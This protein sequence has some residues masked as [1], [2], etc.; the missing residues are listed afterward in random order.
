ML[1]DKPQ[2]QTTLDTVIDAQPFLG[3]LNADPTARGIFGALSL[4]QDRRRTGPRR[5]RP[6]PCRR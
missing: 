2:L 6:L 5:Y 3:A 4:I 1:L